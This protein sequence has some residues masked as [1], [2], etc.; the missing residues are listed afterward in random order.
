MSSRGPRSHP[1]F[2]LASALIVLLSAQGRASPIQMTISGTIGDSQIFGHAIVPRTITLP[3]GLSS[4]SD[5]GPIDLASADISS[6]KSKLGLPAN[7]LSPGYTYTEHGPFDIRLTFHAPGHSTT[8]GDAATIDLTGSSTTTFNV[9]NGHESFSV[10]L[11]G[12]PSGSITTGPGPGSSIPPSLLT[13]FTSVPFQLTGSMSQAKCGNK[14][15]LALSFAAAEQGSGSGPPGTPTPEP[16]TIL[17]FGV[18]SLSAWIARSRRI[19]RREPPRSPA[20]SPR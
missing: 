7:Q 16:G 9:A 14:F 5:L 20:D 6:Q 19:R 12:T 17:I 10:A 13:Q 8:S 4:A 3:D 1:S 2:R 18:G 15:Q 11:S